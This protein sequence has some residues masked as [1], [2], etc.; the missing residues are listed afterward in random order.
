MNENLPTKKLDSKDAE[1]KQ[2]KK[3]LKTQEKTTESLKETLSNNNN[4]LHDIIK[5]KKELTNKIQEYDLKLVDAKLN[6]FQRLQEDHLKTVHRLQVT[7]KQ[8]DEANQRITELNGKNEELELVIAG[9]ES[10]GILDY[11][12]GKYPESYQAY[13][14]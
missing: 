10:R 6:Q 12:R 3:E 5:E 7:K 2:L 4:M 1:I 14:K 13:K 9:L 11:I 8:L